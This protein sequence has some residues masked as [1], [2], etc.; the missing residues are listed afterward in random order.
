MARF[1]S[2]LAQS[3]AQV[4]GGLAALISRDGRMH[5]IAVDEGT[6]LIVADPFGV[7]VGLVLAT[8]RRPLVELPGYV[9]FGRADANQGTALTFPNGKLNTTRPV[10]I[11]RVGAG[12]L[13]NLKTWTPVWPVPSDLFRVQIVNGR[14][15]SAGLLLKK[16]LYYPLSSLDPALL[17]RHARNGQLIL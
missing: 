12:R 7:G 5:G 4:D 16:D 15:Q 11:Q 14:A 8:K 1:V 10:E 2:F 17:L 3:Q 6:A 9:F 13:F